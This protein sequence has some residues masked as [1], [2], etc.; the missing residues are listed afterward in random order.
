MLILLDA[1]ADVE[2]RKYYPVTNFQ[3]FHLML[4][5]LYAPNN[6]YSLFSIRYANLM[7]IVY[8]LRHVKIQRVVAKAINI[9]KTDRKFLFFA[10]KLLVT[11]GIS[12]SPFDDIFFQQFLIKLRKN[13]FHSE[14]QLNGFLPRIKRLQSFLELK[15]NMVFDSAHC[16]VIIISTDNI[17]Y[18]LFVRNKLWCCYSIEITFS[19]RRNH[20]QRNFNAASNDYNYFPINIGFVFSF[21]R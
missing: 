12:C 10:A 9:Y 5:V 20:Q 17:L 14:H 4:R 11:S 13:Y 18:V 3:I 7:I 8:W 21:F 15:Y 16:S 1:V 19:S 6:L 2:T